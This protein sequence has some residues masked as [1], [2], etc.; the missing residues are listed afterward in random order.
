MRRGRWPDKSDIM[1]SVHQS[2]C[3][4]GALVS[5]D[6]LHEVK[7][8]LIERGLSIQSESRIANDSGEVLKLKQGA[9][10]NVYENGRV[11]VQGGKREF[12]QELQTVIDSRLK[13]EN[14]EIAPS[15]KVFVV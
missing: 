13:A 5:H 14:G 2:C 11:F 10:V 1:R 6:V 9:V 12:V 8:I 15:R 3:R 7:A 4:E